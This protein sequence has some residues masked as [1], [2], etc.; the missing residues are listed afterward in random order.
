MPARR[1]AWHDAPEFKQYVEDWLIPREVD[2]ADAASYVPADRV[3]HVGIEMSDAAQLERLRTWGKSYAGFFARL[4]ED[5]KINTR[6]LGRNYLHN[7]TYPT[8]DAEVYAAMIFDF[9]PLTILEIGAGY[10]TL[11][12]RKTAREL[13]EPCRVIAVDP[14]PRTDL[15]GEA[16]AVIARHVEAIP[17]ETLPVGRRSLLFI[18]S[19]HIVRSGGDVPYIY[20][21]LLPSLLAGTLV[22]VHD[23]FLPYDYPAMYKRRL[24]T[25]QYV[26]QA[27]L[28]HSDRY[29]VVFATHYMT[30]KY[31]EAMRAI[32]GDVVGREDCYYGASFWLEVR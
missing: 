8:P 11:I 29:R 2:G 23:I 24:Y 16:D 17:L 21:A 32:F 27:L 5:P 22:H 28:S 14:E 3:P 18:D 19:S 1:S 31:P 30:R 13:A 10:S 25:E 20:N 26:L 6:C 15:A 9:R 12:A 7:G 4:R